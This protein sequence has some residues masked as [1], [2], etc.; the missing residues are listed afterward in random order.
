MQTITLS[1][2]GQITLPAGIRAHLGLK[3]GDRMVALEEGGRIVLKPLERK[4]FWEAEGLLD[5]A[6]NS[7][8]PAA[9]DMRRLAADA[10]VRRFRRAVRSPR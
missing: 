5:S 2:K 3:T 4:S 9:P 1:A 7:R 6:G 8:G 10:A